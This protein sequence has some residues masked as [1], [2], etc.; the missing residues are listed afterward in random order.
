MPLLVHTLTSC[1]LLVNS[2]YLTGNK[3]KKV[4]ASYI[5]LLFVPPQSFSQPYL[6]VVSLKTLWREKKINDFWMLSEL[7]VG[8][9][10][11]VSSYETF[12]EFHVQKAAE[13]V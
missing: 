5:F 12:L 4:S 7:S 3:G 2:T 8:T 9:N 11:L 13:Q 1:E 6:R 10:T